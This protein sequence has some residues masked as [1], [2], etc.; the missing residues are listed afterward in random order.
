MAAGEYLVRMV[1]LRTV[2][3]VL[4]VPVTTA[5]VACSSSVTGKGSSSGPGT[6]APGSGSAPQR[7][8]APHSM[9]SD[10]AGLGALMK[11]GVSSITSAHI[12]LDVKAAGQGI[13]GSGDETFSG[14]KLTAFDLTETIGSTGT[15]RLRIVDSKTYVALPASLNHSGKPWALV[16]ANSSDPVI[17]SMNQSINSALSSASLDSVSLFVTAAKSVKLDGSDSVDGAAATR[18]SVVVD[19][20]RLPGDYPGRQTLVSAGLSTLPVDLW[21]NSQGRPVKVSE[22]FSV[23][24]QS[25]STQ[26]GVSKYNAPVQIT[27]PPADQVSTS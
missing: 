21:I 1:R 16:T 8:S 13:N 22:K 7:A 23:Q 2:S 18:Y 26:I 4:L 12:S 19:V 20:T 15:L 14:G 27:A 17:K 9:P 25:V 6:G 24:G 10:A 3:I 11:Q 5:L